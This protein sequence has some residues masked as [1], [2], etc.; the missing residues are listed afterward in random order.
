MMRCPFCRHT[1]HVKTS[2]Y[3]SEQVKESYHQCTNLE[4]SST[5]KTHENIVKVITPPPEPERA[6]VAAPPPSVRER[7][8]LGR[9]GS[10]F[11]L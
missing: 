8:T 10:A 9:Y 2:R 3:L 1:S 5:F 11:R 6:T 4:C 7:Q